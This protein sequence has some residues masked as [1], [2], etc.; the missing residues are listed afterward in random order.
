MVTIKFIEFDDEETFFL[1]SGEEAAH[2]SMGCI[3]RHRLS[4]PPSM[5]RRSSRNPQ[6]AN[7]GR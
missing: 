7:G 3:R 1:G 2:A 4:V 6:L 5:A